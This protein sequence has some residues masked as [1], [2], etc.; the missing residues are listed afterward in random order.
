MKCRRII[1]DRHT[2]WNIKGCG[3]AARVSTGQRLF[4][5]GRDVAAFTP[6]VAQMCHLRFFHVSRLFDSLTGRKYMAKPRIERSLLFPN[7]EF[8]ERS[9]EK[10]RRTGASDPNESIYPRRLPNARFAGVMTPNP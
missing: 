8:R 6:N 2:Y 10:R 5:R 3:D 4:F 1:R 7:K 9:A